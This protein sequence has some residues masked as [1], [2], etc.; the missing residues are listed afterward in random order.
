MH[1]NDNINSLSPSGR[2]IVAD[3]AGRRGIAPVQLDDFLNPKLALDRCI[4]PDAEKVLARLN[5]AAASR[6]RVLIFGDYDCDGL[7][8]VA[9]M[10]RFLGEARSLTPDW[11]LPNRQTDHYGLDVDKAK[12]LFARFRPSLLICLDCGTNSA[13]AEAF[14]WLKKQGVNTIVVD[15]HPPSED[16]STDAVATVNPKAHLALETSDL[17]DLCAAG[18]A[19]VLCNYLAHAWHCAD[20]WDCSAATVLAGLGTLADA[21]PMSAV[22]RSIAKNAISLINVPVV[23][24]WIT[25]LAALV[26]ADGRRITQRQLQFE[27]I[28]A[29][30]ALGSRPRCN[31]R[32]NRRTPNRRVNRAN[33]AGQ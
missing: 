18:L 17:G 22:N 15:H 11:S 29:I 28:P 13:A 33:A 9:I 25:G 21:V 10:L 5:R 2:R 12:T 6:E 31:K 26:P 7:T 16:M 14:A 23:L 30:N 3:Y 19:L 4:L 20:R 8:A 32:S 27:I 24:N 1:S